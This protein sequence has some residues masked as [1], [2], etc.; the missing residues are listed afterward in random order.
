MRG[1]VFKGGWM[2]SRSRKHLGRNIG[3][4][5]AVIVILLVAVVAG[6][7]SGLFGES[8]SP[9]QTASPTPA[10]ATGSVGVNVGDTFTYKLNGTSVL[11]SADAKTPKEFAQYNN[12]DSYQVIITNVAGYSVSFNTLWRFKNGTILGKQQTIDLSNGQASDANGFWAIYLPNLNAQD[13]LHHSSNDGLIVNSTDTQTFANSTRVRNY[14]STVKQFI[15][16][17]DTSGNTFR[18]E[19]IGVYFD[20]QTGM[21]ENLTQIEFYTNPEVELIVTWQL[22]SSSVWDV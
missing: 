8:I 15:D 11:G 9:R 2:P 12:T 5:V 22:T 4:A 7:Y 13:T 18:N 17:N 10:N 19:F 20:K 14:W 16:A 21:L 1:I 6:L 3:I